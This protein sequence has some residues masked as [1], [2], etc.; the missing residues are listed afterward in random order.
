MSVKMGSGKVSS[1][2]K[3]PQMIQLLPKVVGSS[4]GVSSYTQSH[5]RCHMPGVIR[6]T[7][8]RSVKIAFVIVNLRGR[9][10]ESFD[11]SACGTYL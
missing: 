10:D 7:P 3:K 2:L 1:L 8:S 6:I 4:I 9:I 11:N 5:C